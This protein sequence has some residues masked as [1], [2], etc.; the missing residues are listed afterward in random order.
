MVNGFELK[1]GDKF[2]FNYMNETGTIGGKIATLQK[3]WFGTTKWHPDAGILV[4]A[5]DSETNQTR[6]FYAMDMTEIE[7][8]D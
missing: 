3:F 5:I 2:R 4:E 7:K 6:Y 1:P 8:V